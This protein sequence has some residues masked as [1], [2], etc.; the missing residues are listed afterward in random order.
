V[1]QNE[2]AV[3]G[4]IA[5]EGG[6]EDVAPEGGE[7]DVAP[8]DGDEEMPVDEAEIQGN[9]VDEE[10]EE[11]DGDFGEIIPDDTSSLGNSNKENEAPDEGMSEEQET[12]E[13]DTIQGVTMT[14][15]IEEEMAAR[16]AEA[17]FGASTSAM[18]VPIQSDG[19]P[20]NVTEE[21]D[22]NSFL[23]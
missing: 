3:E 17:L 19:E 15:S 1:E 16:A 5:P 18:S 11:D 6:E 22:L 8:E 9:I 21:D 12:M 20:S 2:D 13:M 4:D 23:T 7:E 14:M 10:E